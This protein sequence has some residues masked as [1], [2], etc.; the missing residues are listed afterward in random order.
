MITLP[1]SFSFPICDF[2]LIYYL[3]IMQMSNDLEGKQ[4]ST[5][6]KGL[7]SSCGINIFLQ[8]WWLQNIR[9]HQANKGK[10]SH[11]QELHYTAKSQ[12]CNDVPDWFYKG[13]EGRNFRLP[14]FPHRLPNNKATSQPK[15][16]VRLLERQTEVVS[17]T[18]EIMLF[19][20]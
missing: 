14:V 8:I 16:Q 3:I 13:V 18:H 7:I 4:S 20:V 17:D 15:C 11:S 10:V 12:T 1:K 6:F 2:S 9:L 5:T 19:P